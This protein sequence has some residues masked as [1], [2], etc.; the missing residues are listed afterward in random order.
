MKKAAL[1]ALAL[2]IL[3]LSGCGADIPANSDGYYGIDNTAYGWGLKKEKGRAPEVPEGVKRVLDEHNAIYIGS[4]EG[5]K[6]CLT[7][8]EGY[9]NGHTAQILDILAE[10]SVPAAFF[11]TGDY[12]NRSNDL[13]ARM[14]A[15]GH[16]VG[17]HT[18]YHHN[19][20]RLAEA[21]KIAAELEELEDKFREQ[22]GFEMKYMRPPEGV[23][24]E[25]VLAVAADMGYKTAFWSFAYKDW[26]ADDVR[27]AEYALSSIEPYLHPGAIL[28]LHAVSADNADALGTLIDRA[29]ADGYEFVSLDEI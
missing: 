16:I 27:G 10:K 26:L 7:F 22:F 6:L 3:I 18:Y 17:N 28:L 1:A 8:D 12:F 15:D 13:V 21:D 24:S 23:Y 5:K 25:R 29:R 11:V 2:P 9:E 14:V 20:P 19:L 4:G